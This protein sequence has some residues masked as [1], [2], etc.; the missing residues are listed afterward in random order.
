M[1]IE[2][3]IRKMY[4]IF[5]NI[6]LCNGRLIGLTGGELYNYELGTALKELGHDVTLTAEETNIFFEQKCSE[7]NINYCKINHINN[8]N[9]Y[10][11]IIV[12]NKEVVTKTLNFE[13][14]SNNLI[15]ICHSEIIEP[16][17][18]PL[19]IS[20]VSKYVAIRPSIKNRLI[21]KFCI[22]EH[23][24]QVIRNPI[25]LNRFNTDGTTDQKFGLFVGTMGGVRFKAAF[26]FAQFCKINNI[27]SI[28]ISDEG[29]Q[30][31]FFDVYLPRCLEIEK[32]FKS[33]SISGGVL[34]GRTYFEAR[35]CGKPTIE[36]FINSMG[37]ITNIDYEDAPDEVEITQLQYQF[38]KINVAKKIIEV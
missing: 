3:I 14:F 38:N 4:K 18:D 16:W 33:C 30:I 15:N 34:H 2:N 32:Y 27:K 28:Y 37:E 24:I 11:I 19:I 10:D 22:P 12:S 5:V 17:D 8:L 36:Y 29:Q 21:N 13:K 23:K 26:H 31:P 20:N 7:K 25:N 9:K 6:L 1:F 35:L